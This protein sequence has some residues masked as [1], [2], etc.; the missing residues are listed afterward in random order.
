MNKKEV[1]KV[2]IKDHH[3]ARE[4][5]VSRPLVRALKK[6]K[7]NGV[8]NFIT[9]NGIYLYG[10]VLDDKFYEIFTGNLLDID[11]LVYQIVPSGELLSKMKFLSKDEIRKIHALVSKLVFGSQE[12]TDF[13]E[14][15]SLQEL[16]SDRASLFKE[17]NQDLSYINPYEK[18][19]LT[20]Y[21]KSLVERA[22]IEKSIVSQIRR[23]IK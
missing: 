22:A 14:I 11:N 7:S 16:A 9:S 10:Y 5:L 19:A 3:D 2:L 17:Y 8:D 13:M 23:R 6:M 4:D 20:N 12:N 1:A 21:N 15:S 18:G